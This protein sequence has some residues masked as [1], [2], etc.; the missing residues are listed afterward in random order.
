[1]GGERDDA[2]GGAPVRARAVWTTAEI[3]DVRERA[4]TQTLKEVAKHYD[5]TVGAL[6][7][8]CHRQ[9]ISF[10]RAKAGLT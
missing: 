4:K 1:M 8:L 3:G 2:H 5:V 6:K 9:G 7:A 10:R